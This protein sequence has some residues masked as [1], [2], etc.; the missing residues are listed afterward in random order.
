MQHRSLTLAVLAFAVAGGSVAYSAMKPDQIPLSAQNGSGESGTATLLQSGDNLYVT[1]RLNND[2]NPQPAHIHKGTCDKLDPKPA[3]PLST[4][5]N[6]KSE[7]KLT[8]ITLA[9]LTASPYAINVHKSLTD[10][11]TYVSC[12]NIVISKTAAP[13]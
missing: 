13:K 12:G 7:T 4:V 3:Y 2:Q 5:Q 9:K 8:G 11:P 1:L 10:I 6:G